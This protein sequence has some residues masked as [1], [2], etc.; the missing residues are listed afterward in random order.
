MVRQIFIGHSILMN[1]DIRESGMK[2]PDHELID[3]A[4]KR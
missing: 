4:K 2:I 1:D 3:Y